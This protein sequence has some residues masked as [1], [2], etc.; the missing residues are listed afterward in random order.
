M[1]VRDTSAPPLEGIAIIGMA[2]RFPGA[3]S[4]A[5]FWRNQLNGI[6][7]ISQF[8]INELEIPSA[9]EVARDPNFGMHDRESINDA[10]AGGQLELR[11]LFRCSGREF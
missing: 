2:G 11:V 5:E 4:V 7:S 9:T 10:R 1:T 3:S 6:E 8:D